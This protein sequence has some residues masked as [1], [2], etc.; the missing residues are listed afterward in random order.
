MCVFMCTHSY[1]MFMSVCV[2]MRER[3]GGGDAG[4]M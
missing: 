4:S 3:E 1:I 2:C